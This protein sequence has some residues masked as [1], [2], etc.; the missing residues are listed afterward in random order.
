MN[1]NALQKLDERAAR[2]NTLLCVGLDSALEHV[3]E[4]FLDEASPH[5]GREARSLRDAINHARA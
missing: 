5:P 4:R 3:P 1:A 2:S